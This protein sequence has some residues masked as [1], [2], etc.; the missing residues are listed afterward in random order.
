MNYD[1]EYYCDSNSVCD[2]VKKLFFYLQD[3]LDTLE[4]MLDI[5]PCQIKER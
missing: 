1:D 5:E 4:I 3:N 2:N